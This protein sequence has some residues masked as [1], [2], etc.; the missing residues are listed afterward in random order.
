M[1]EAIIAAAV[2]VVATIAIMTTVAAATAASLDG[3]CAGW[4]RLMLHRQLGGLEINTLIQE[5]VGSRSE[6][7]ILECIGWRWSDQILLE[8]WR[9]LFVVGIVVVIVVRSIIMLI[10]LVIVSIMVIVVI[11]IVM[12]LVGALIIVVAI[13]AAAA[14]A[15]A[16]MPARAH[17]VVATVAIIAIVVV[18]TSWRIV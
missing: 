14:I 7:E 12:V 13:T 9:Q 18:A 17:N 1:N 6:L 10:V 16:A 11:V 5:T 3:R 15:T 4:T 2:A 8:T